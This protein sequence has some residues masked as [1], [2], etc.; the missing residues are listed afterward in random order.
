MSDLPSYP[1]YIG[2][3]NSQEML[4]FRAELRALLSLGPECPPS[5]NPLQWATTTST[6]FE[7]FTDQRRRVLQ[8]PLG[9]QLD[10]IAGVL[11]SPLALQRQEFDLIGRETIVF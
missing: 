11:S 4:R 9:S 10:E 5:P 6:L 3:E 7:N 1:D 2:F 8:H